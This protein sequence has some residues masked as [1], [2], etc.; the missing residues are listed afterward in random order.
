MRS[1][2]NALVSV[3]VFLS[4]AAAGLGSDL[5]VPA[6]K[7]GPG[8]PDGMMHR[9]LLRQAQQA[10]AQ[11][12]EQYEERKTPEQIAAYQKKAREE[13]L[14]ALGG[15]PERTPLKAQVT[16]R[17]ARSGYH[18][19][20]IIFQS[21]PSHYVTALLFLPEAAKFKPPYPGVVIPCGHAENAK[22]YEPYQGMGALLALNGMAA[23][24][25][26]PIDQGERKQCLD[27]DLSKLWGV[28]AHINLGI[29][30]ILLGRNTA[31]FEIWDGM[32]AIDYL[33]SR[34]EVDRQRIGCTG[35]SGGGTQTSYLMALD[36]RIRAAAPSCYI[37]S[38]SR[39]LATI[40]PQ[41]SEQHL[42]GQLAA[43]IDHADLIMMRAPSPVLLC[44]ATKDFFDIRGSW[45]SFRYAK[46]LYTRMGFAERVAILEN[47]AGHNYNTLQ[48]EGA[49]RWMSRWLAGKDTPI[50]EPPITLLNQQEYQCT[51]DG[52]VMR[53]PG[54]RSVYDLN[55]DYENE[56]AKKRQAAWSGG[57][58]ATLLEKVRQLAG[59]RKLSDLPKP[60]VESLETVA[61]TG[62]RIEKLLIR[63][64]AGIV[65]PALLFR[66]EKAKPGGIV[67]YVH[68]KGK[69]ADAGSGGPI[70]RLVLAGNT[71]LAVDLRGT[72][73][74]QAKLGNGGYSAEFQDAYVAYLLGRS[75]VGMQAEDVLMAARYLTERFAGGGPSQG[76]RPKGTVPFSRL[77]A[78][79]IGTVPVRLVAVGN[80][81]IPALHAAVLE[82]QLFQR[83]K[84]S[85]TLGSWS[86]VIH[87]RLNRDL[88]THVVHGALL[89]YDLPN[90]AAVLGNKLT[91]D[92]P[93]DAVGAA[94]ARRST[95][96]AAQPPAKP[97]ADGLLTYIGTYTNGASQGV[98]LTRF[99]PARGALRPV[100]LA[101]KV[102]NPSFLAIHPSRPLLYAISELEQPAGKDAGTLSAYAIDP[103]QGKLKLLNRQLSGNKVGCHVIVD[104]SGRYVL[105]ASYGGGTVTCLPILPDGR[106]G[107][108]TCLVKHHGSSV[109]SGRQAGP[110][111]HGVAM[112]PANRFAFV[113]DLGLDKIMIYRFEAGGRLTANDPAYFATAPGAGPRHFVFHPN[114]RYAYVINEINS[115]ITA[116][117]YDAGR[118][119]LHELQTISTLRTSFHGD[120]STA[121]IQVHPSGR[122]LYGSN[123]GHDSI[124]I[125][126]VDEATGKLRLVGYESTRGKTPRNFILDPTGRYLLAANQDSDNIVVFRIDSHTGKLSANG[127]VLAV[128]APV[129][130]AMLGAGR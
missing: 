24:V 94:I 116:L 117:D 63:P 110:H 91:I 38:L 104:R 34:P 8:A 96:G 10:F 17:V 14:A 118:G 1:A 115:T 25:F 129:C 31:R 4:G 81:G 48:R 32:R 124:A 77:P 99:D 90:L 35:N 79:K 84:L 55:E 83:V 105:A 67:L 39:L 92:Q 74:T 95:A 119:T 47:D 44:T 28:A 5:D 102:A 23:L 56:L 69:A 87:H 130:I 100:T 45:D 103:K 64:E 21:Q 127:S 112:D 73:Q 11:W 57:Q 33:Q 111:A 82:P 2:I 76:A 78:A 120:N 20:K 37:T 114:G 42:F 50:V 101:A 30:C 36:D 13:F 49:A 109:V 66:P 3:L 15:L 59:I 128:P 106:L 58:Q 9:Y 93:M 40:G 126:A 27:G 72:G 70:E 85:R 54:A 123:R 88:V 86:S 12:H 108:A 6:A 52:E 53:L 107:E 122:F 125:F 65:L 68:Q 29:G 98:Y 41:D 19:E 16:G 71:V 7:M 18:V 80:V 43:G 62:Y 75:Y 89:H 26:D 22:G 60:Q 97:R 61:R 121:E 113:T 51:P 46:R